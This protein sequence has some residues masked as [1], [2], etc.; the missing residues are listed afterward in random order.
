MLTAGA[1]AMPAQDAPKTP[2]A[3]PAEPAEKKETPKEESSVTEHSIKVG[4]QTINYTATAG[5]ILL[6][7]EKDEPTAS[8]FYMAYTRSDAKDL[9]QRPLSF[10]YNGGPGSSSAWLHMGA[11]GPRRVEAADAEST[12]PPPYRLTDNAYSLIDKT[13]V[14]FIDPVGTGFSRAVGKAKDKDFWG[15]DQDV[16]SLAQFITTYVSRNNRWNSPKYLLGESYGT[17]R[18]AALVNYLQDHKHMDFNGVVLIS[19]VLDLSTLVFA[20]GDD[21]CYVFYLPSYAATAWYHKMLK[22]PPANLEGFLAEARHFAV[23]EY[24]GALVK[25]SKISAAEKAEMAGKLSIYTGLSEDY[26]IKANLRVTLSQFRQELQRSRGETTGR[27]D[28]RYSG[29]TFDLLGE[30]AEYDPQSTS[31]SGAFTAA[32]N[33]YVREELKFGRDKDYIIISEQA[34]RNW[35]WKRQGGERSFFPFAPNVEGDLAEALIANPHL[36]VE[37]ENGI[38]DLATP[39]FASEFTMEHLGLP[40]KLQ[41]HIQQKYYDAGHMMYLNQAALAKLKE[42]IARFIDSTSHR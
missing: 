24:A 6:K 14:V 32:F 3:K 37:V 22:D 17:F 30:H 33:S 35:D 42:N 2:E 13:D 28:A 29:F 7:D 27:L 10:S 36:Q 26:L 23:T 9:S 39:F 1:S 8:I 15:V 41:G 34:G 21:R 5:T 31:I 4:G 12:P 20:P 40:E 16:K 25:G 19:N 18:S 11:F 38:F